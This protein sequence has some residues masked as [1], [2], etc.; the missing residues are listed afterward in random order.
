MMSTADNLRDEQRAELANA[1]KSIEDAIALL[2]TAGDKRAN[3]LLHDAMNA[4]S[5]V[6][7]GDRSD[8]LSGPL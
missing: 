6:L 4:V 5:H 3:K 8:E 7:S 2:N 1:I